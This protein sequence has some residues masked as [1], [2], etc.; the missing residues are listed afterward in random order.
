MDE[1]EEQTYL[2]DGGFEQEDTDEEGE[3]ASGDEG[4]V[5]EDGGDNKIGFKEQENYGQSNEDR[6]RDETVLE[7]K[8]QYNFAKLVSVYDQIVKITENKDDG[9]IIALRVGIDLID[10][11]KDKIIDNT[12]PSFEFKSGAGL[13]LG[14]LCVINGN[15]VDEKRL[16][17]AS[18]VGKKLSMYP[19]LPFD[20]LRYAYFWI[21]IINDNYSEKVVRKRV[22]TRKKKK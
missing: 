8:Y 4:G 3:L 19:I 5:E 18:I 20:I 6:I 22:I 16:T 7:H 12:I 17:D 9:D 10:L 1:F 21:N 2:Y 15:D 14:Y 11:I 13:I